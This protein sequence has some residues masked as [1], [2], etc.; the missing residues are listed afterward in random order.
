MEDLISR[1][2]I[3]IVNSKYAV[4]LTGAGISTESGIRDFRG[5]DGIWTKNPDAERIA[6][7]TYYTFLENP[8]DYW[9]ER[10]TKPYILG[11]ID[12]ASPNPGHI[13]LAELE[14]MG[15]LKAVI[16][17]NID[18]LHVKA[19]HDRVLEYHGSIFKL[20]CLS[21]GS[22]YFVE[23][24]DIE[25]LWR[26]KQLPPRCRNCNS[27]LK[28]D[29]VHF[30]EGIPADVSSE[31]IQE[32]LKCDVMLICGT[33]AVVYPFAGLPRLVRSQSSPLQISGNSD[34]K[35]VTIIEIN[36][37]P[38]PLTAEHVSDYLIKG[39]TAQI[40]P[41]IVDEVKRMTAQA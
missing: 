23:E 1:A 17:Q 26:N 30:N 6:Y 21:C 19:G 4:T 41:R 35:P 38:T 9:E 24:F 10:I 25:G 27:A 15:F 11:D 40:L 18:G 34:S 3:D 32:V 33:S 14:K 28:S 36:A 13:A 29:I 12:K 8:R 37:E 39:R 16:T 31:S 2:A 7:E 22:R 5:P 20:R